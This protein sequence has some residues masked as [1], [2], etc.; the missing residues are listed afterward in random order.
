M[1][2]GLHLTLDQFHQVLAIYVNCCDK[3]LVWETQNLSLVMIIQKGV[4][5]LGLTKRIKKTVKI[6][7]KLTGD[8]LKVVISWAF[9]LYLIWDSMNDPFVQEAY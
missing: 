3:G 4:H 8:D 7:L 9:G 5:R 2:G 1:T 6:Y